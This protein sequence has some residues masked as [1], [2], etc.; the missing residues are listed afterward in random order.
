MRAI[1]ASIL[2]LIFSVIVAGLCIDH[3]DIYLSNMD[4]LSALKEA[5]RVAK[6][7]LTKSCNKISREIIEDSDVGSLSQQVSL[8]KT[9][10]VEFSDAHDSV[11]TSDVAEDI[12]HQKYYLQVESNYL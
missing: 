12:D 1:P 9:T 4:E 6:I 5:R 2:L 3:T 8:L 7:K 10:F 11:V